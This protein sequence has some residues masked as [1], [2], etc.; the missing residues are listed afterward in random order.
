ME[1]QQVQERGAQGDDQRDH[2]ALLRRLLPL[3]VLR[4]AHRRVRGAFSLP[5]VH[6]RGVQEKGAGRC[7][8]NREEDRAPQFPRLGFCMC[9]LV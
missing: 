2:R 4:L 9:H 1:Q 3:P 7:Q 5:D 8:E 6:V